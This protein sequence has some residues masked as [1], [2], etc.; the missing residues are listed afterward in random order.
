MAHSGKAYFPNYNRFELIR[1]HIVKGYGVRIFSQEKPM[2]QKV[3]LTQRKKIEYFSRG[4]L[5]KEFEA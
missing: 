2:A 1:S 5:L 3:S 4:H